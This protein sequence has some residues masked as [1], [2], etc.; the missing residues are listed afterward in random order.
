MLSKALLI[1]YYILQFTSMSCQCTKVS[2]S[3]HGRQSGLLLIK[4]TEIVGSFLQNILS[5]YTSLISI[6]VKVLSFHLF[7]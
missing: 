4:V 5:T 3:N 2:I 6:N 1:E 7:F